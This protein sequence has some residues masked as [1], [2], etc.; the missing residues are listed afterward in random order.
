MANSLLCI[1]PSDRLS[2]WRRV[3]P[4]SYTVVHVASPRAASALLTDG[5]TPFVAAVVDLAAGP[6]VELARLRELA[7]LLPML[8]LMHQPSGPA[9]NFLHALRCEML[10]GEPEAAALRDFLARS[11]SVGRLSA[12]T[13]DHWI[14]RMVAKR[15]LRPGDLELIPV[16]LGDESAEH[17]RA[18]LGFTPEQMTRRMRALCRRCG[19][20]TAVG[21][22][23]NLMRDALLFGRP[24][25]RVGAPLRG[26]ASAVA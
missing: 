17:A 20:R 26:L 13:V 7:P 21:A 23:R 16:V 2:Q 1:A 19:A 15:E 3:L 5:E 4:A 25:P 12:Q 6:C 9:I 18:R 14:D 24:A 8:A 11:G 22:H 10:C